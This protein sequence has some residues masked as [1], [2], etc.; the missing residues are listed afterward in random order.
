M[1]RAVLLRDEVGF[2]F[3]VTEDCA[4]FDECAAYVD[5]YGEHVYDIEYDAEHLPEACEA[6]G[7][8]V[9]RDLD[10]AP[11]GSP[12]YVFEAC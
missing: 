11:A 3:A 9:L 2:D 4:Q 12:G 6:V 5:V 7:S 1:L 10:L 8:A